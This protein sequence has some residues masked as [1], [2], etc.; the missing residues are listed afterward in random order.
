VSDTR[1]PRYRLCI[2][3]LQ[4][5]KSTKVID[6]YGSGFITAI[7]TLDGDDLE[8]HFADGGPRKLLAHIAAAITDEYS[9]RRRR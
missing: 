5:G 1:P 2:Y 3:Q 4:G 8:V 9:R 6:Y 7:A